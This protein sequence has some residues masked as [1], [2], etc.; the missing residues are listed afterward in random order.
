MAC[1][2]DEVQVFKQLGFKAFGQFFNFHSLTVQFGFFVGFKTNIRVLTGRRFD[3]DHFRFDFVCLLQTA[4]CLTGFGFVRREA[5]NELLQLLQFLFGFGVVFQGA[6]TR[7]GGSKH[8]VVVVARIDGDGVVVQ[9]RHMGADFVQKVTVVRDDNHGGVVLVQHA[10]QPADGINVQVIGRFVQKQYIWLGEQGLRQQ[11]AQLEAR[12]DFCHGRIVQIFGNA[13]AAQQFGSACFGSVAVVFGKLSFQFG[14][15]HVVVFGSFGVGVNR[16]T[17]GHR[18]P[19][20]GMAHHH[21]VQH[22]HVFVGKLV[23]AQFTQTHAVFNRY[24]AGS[25]FQIAAEDFH[26]GGFA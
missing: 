8:I 6:L 12:G 15:F 19:H 14:G 23:L 21:Y 13:H 7:L 20:F 9:I 26:E 24:F 2:K 1:F 3:F 4:G 22:A 16:I 18:R 25:L 10:F 5:C 17:L 11:Y